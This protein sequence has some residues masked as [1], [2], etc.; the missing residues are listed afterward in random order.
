MK[1]LY[2]DCSM[3]AAGDM[4]TAALL[5][6]HPNK[7]DFLS[8]LNAALDG[9]AVVSA[10][11]DIK[12]GI[13]GT[14]V[15]V[16]I[17]GD[18]EG[19]Q[20]HR[21]HRSTSIGE[22][23]NFIA[24]LEL[25]EKVK[26]DAGG[27]YK[28]IARAE[29]EVH[30]E[31][32]ENIHFHEVGSLDA[33]ADILSVCMLIYELNPDKICASPVNV[34]SGTVKCAHGI[35]PVPSPATEKILHGVPVYSGEVK[36]ELCTPTGAAL[37]KYFVQNFGAMPDMVLDNT[38]YGT[39]TKDYKA[40]NVV[41]AMLGHI[42]DNKE[43]IIELSCNIDDMSAEDLSFS[44]ERLF[45]AGALDV[46]FTSIGMKKC[47]PGVMLTCICKEAERDII[48][49]CIFKHTTTLGV[50]EHIC[51]RY[52]LSRSFRTMDTEY[53]TVTVK[54]AEGY[55]VTREKPEYEDLARIAREKG[56]SMREVRDAIKEM[57]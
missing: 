55:G 47:R 20:L 33:L 57:Q 26:N 30:G 40:A 7:D 12:C 38:G 46:Y 5:E 21:R 42:D 2:I 17:N 6:L 19:A 25:P 54:A 22:V 35:L 36:G 24:A 37:L 43:Q 10:A 41:R 1:S 13:G 4:L 56:L 18:E 51:N 23:L 29:S 14:H 27:V 8:R 39:G 32:M 15:S 53:G 49:H 52:N 34:G 9:K 50:R 3:G 48:L 31:A 11:Q 28:L 44:M 45:E 16:K